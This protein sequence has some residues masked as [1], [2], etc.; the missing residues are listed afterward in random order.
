MNEI[1]TL[2]NTNEM[3]T[4]KTQI[5]ISRRDSRVTVSKMIQKYL[6]FSSRYES[7]LLFFLLQ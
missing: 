4:S 3:K 2:E 1:L 6:T 7:R 5:S